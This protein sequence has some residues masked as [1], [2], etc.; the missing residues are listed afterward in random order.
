MMLLFGEYR[1]VWKMGEA[2]K[3]T[4]MR[5]REAGLRYWVMG[6]KVIRERQSDPS[7]KEL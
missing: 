4:E 1:G 7:V 6:S 2:F 3:S 5:E